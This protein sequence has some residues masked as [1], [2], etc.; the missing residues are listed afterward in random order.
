M[1]DVTAASTHLLAHAPGG[2]G[3]SVW[4]AIASV[5]TIC[6]AAATYGA[7]LQELWNKRGRG[8]V[9]GMRHAAAFLTGLL[10]L[11]AT[12]S[13]AADRLAERSFA[14]H[15]TQHM[16]ILIVVAPLLA[17]GG[18]GLVLT[19][20]LPHS[21][22]RLLS[23]IRT[24]A[25]LRWTRKPLHRSLIGGLLFTG[26]LWLWHLPA[27]YML[28]EDNEGVHA[29]EHV[30]YLVVAWLLF[31]AVLTPARH[32]LNGPLAFLLLFAVGMAGAALG[33]V[34]TF[35]PAPLYPPQAFAAGADALNDQ[36]LAGLIMWIPMDVVVMG[37]AL[38][39]FGHWINDLG[40]EH[41]AGP[42]RPLQEAM[43]P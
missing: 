8:E 36:Q 4:A 40:V 24:S 20:A 16:V 26:V 12:L 33:A 39:V 15:M 2:H 21:A 37:I 6:V 9:V 23:R 10:L 7:G 13:P 35:A 38:T 34:L 5:V 3:E 17:L 25:P 31:A 1:R 22:R 42:A 28:A 19:M 29:I 30:S 11:G 14:G 18:A 32:R 27:A 41:P 43:S